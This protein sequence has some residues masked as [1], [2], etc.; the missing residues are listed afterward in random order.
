L[1]LFG[2]AGAATPATKDNAVIVLGLGDSLMAGYGLEPKDAFTVRL[3]ARLK[4]AG[5]NARVVNAGV[6]GDTTS[7]GRARLSWMLDGMNTPPDLIVL[8]LGANDAL[9]GIPPKLSRDNL[10][11]MLAEIRRRGIRVL[12]AGMRAPPNMGRDYEA[13]FN[14][15]YPALARKHGVPLYPF[16]LEGV[17]AN[18][19]LNQADGIHPNRQG[20]EHIARRIAPSAIG[21]LKYRRRP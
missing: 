6:S 12:L 8:E 17:A 7:G 15:I 2:P 5:V 13:A 11:A 16:F 3:E 10:D 18:P 4:A 20:V 9:R 19:R 14:A 1:A 21:A